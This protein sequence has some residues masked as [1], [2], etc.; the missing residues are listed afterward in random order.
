MQI[1]W[2]LTNRGVHPES[3]DHRSRNELVVPLIRHVVTGHDPGQG[4]HQ[5]AEYLECE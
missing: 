3:G 2:V 1:K 5:T 4:P